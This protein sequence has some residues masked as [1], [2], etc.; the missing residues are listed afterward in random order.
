MA[1]VK[2]ASREFLRE[3]IQLYQSLPC[4]WNIKSKE[5]SNRELR[6]WAYE[7]L[8]E[9]YKSIDR[10]AN[11][12][13][14]KKKINSLRSTYNKERHKVQASI[15]NSDKEIYVPT[16]WYYNLLSF[17]DD[18]DTSR[19]TNHSVQDTSNAVDVK[20]DDELSCSYWTPQVINP[21]IS[22]VLYC[23]N[24]TKCDIN[25]KFKSCLC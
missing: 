21:M 18:L 25:S 13:T 6:A 11:R 4:L 7:K 8:I 10:E 9:Q 22:P 14:I 17:L 3:F 24:E 15:R 19:D 5:Y 23:F 16:L 20:V 1:D 12:E 2:T